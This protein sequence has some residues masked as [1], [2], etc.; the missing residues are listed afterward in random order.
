MPSS[1]LPS[2]HTRPAT[3]V[4][5]NQSLI[6]LRT[7]C[8]SDRHSGS[9]ASAA[10]AGFMAHSLL[11]SD[12]IPVWHDELAVREAREKEWTAAHPL[13]SEEPA[14]YYCDGD[15]CLRALLIGEQWYR[16]RQCEKKGELIDLCRQCHLGAHDVMRE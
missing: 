16:C 13:K 10:A 15:G 1:L 3:H 2:S 5:V 9:S 12:R 14:G 6:H 4:F 7:A 11:S 8:M